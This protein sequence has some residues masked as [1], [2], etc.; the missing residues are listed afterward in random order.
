MVDSVLQYLE[1][2]ILR[3]RIGPGE[4][5]IETAIADQLGVGR[6]TI[7]EAF[8]MLQQRGLVVSVPRRGTFVTRISREDA[9][10]LAY[11][12]ALLEGFAVRVGWSRIDTAVIDQLQSHL[13][14]MRLH[15][16]P[17]DVPQMIQIDLAF[18]QTLI[19]TAQM[20]RLQELWSSLNGQIGALFI[21]GIEEQQ[22][23]AEAVA[24]LHENVI[25]GLQS[26]NPQ[27]AQPAILAHYLRKGERSSDRGVALSEIVA[28]FGSL[29]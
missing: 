3:G 12:R 8:L 21:R 20:P 26:G 1:E 5:L 4:R 7:R 24:V 2:G 13:A 16:F 23:D 27:I 9:L 6:T 18:H 22:F 10:D 28:A 19:E 17:D 29:V 25:A 15:Q 14:A 11:S